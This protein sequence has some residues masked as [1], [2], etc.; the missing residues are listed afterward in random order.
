MD[1]QIA[2][3]GESLGHAVSV[4]RRARKMKQADLASQVGIGMNTMVEIEKG[5]TTVQFGYYLKVFCALGME[6]TFKPIINL[7]SDETAIQSMS[8]L[9]PKRVAGKRKSR[10]RHQD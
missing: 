10:Y 8:A 7:M 2:L 1:K 4:S 3:I 9:L 6:D 5:S